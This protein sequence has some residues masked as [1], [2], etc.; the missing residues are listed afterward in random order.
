MQLLGVSHRGLKLLK[1]TQGPSFH[2]DQLKTLCSYRWAGLEPGLRVGW[3]DGPQL[4]PH[5]VCSFAEVL[6]VE[7][8]GSSTLELSLKNEQLVLCTARA[9]A[10]KA[11]VNQFLSELRKVRAGWV[12]GQSAACISYRV[13]SGFPGLRLGV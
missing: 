3:Q 9:R 10:I 1:V 4:M 12:L 2:L 7:C 8:Q 5:P 6:G 11:T 13:L